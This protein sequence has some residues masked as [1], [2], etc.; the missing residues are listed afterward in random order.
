LICEIEDPDVI[1]ERTG[2]RYFQKF[3][4]GQTDLRKQE[5]SGHPTDIK[6]VP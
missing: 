1:N 2:R 5:G 6:I 4:N 3:E